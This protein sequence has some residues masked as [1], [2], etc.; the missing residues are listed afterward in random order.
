VKANKGSAGIDGM[1]IDKF[2][3]FANAN[4]GDIK[5]QI[6]QGKY[7]PSPV[8]RVNIPKPDGGTRALGIPTVL[9]RLFS[10]QSIK[11]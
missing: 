5:Q 1:S 2:P 11:Y 4:W 10:K 3:S 8:L 9:D 7:R 6:I